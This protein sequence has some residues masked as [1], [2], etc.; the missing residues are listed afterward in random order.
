MGFGPSACTGVS[1]V[2]RGVD[3]IGETTAAAGKTCRR[4]G[5]SGCLIDPLFAA[6]AVILTA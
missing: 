3:P 5:S 2:A 4:P 1:A 6:A